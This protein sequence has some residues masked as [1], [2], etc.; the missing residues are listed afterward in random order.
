MP[1]KIEKELC[2]ATGLKRRAREDAQAWYAR[3]TGKVGELENDAWDGLSAE[4]QEWSNVATR[5]VNDS[6]TIEGFPDDD[7]APAPKDEPEV[8][9]AK[10]KRVK[11]KAKEEPE[12]AEDEDEAE[13][14][15]TEEDTTEDEVEEEPEEEPEKK[16]K[17]GKRIAA[18]AA[19]GKKAKAD[20]DDDQEETDVKGKKT[21]RKPV[22]S[23]TAIKQFLLKDPNTTV[24]DLLK[25]C[26]AQGFSPSKMAVGSIRSGFR[27]SLKVIIEAGGIPKGLKV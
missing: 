8:K 11:A 21:P 22:G 15:D 13:D 6:V 1:S 17:R 23:Q 25:K 24:D 3:L 7:E 18:K 14:D 10:N 12:E 19:N 16:P 4:A 20:D 2:K 5:A 27:H 26:E 9:A